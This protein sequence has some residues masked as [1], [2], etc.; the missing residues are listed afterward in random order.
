MSSRPSSSESLAF[1]PSSMGWAMRGALDPWDD[2]DVGLVS[3]SLFASR[4][5]VDAAIGR[6]S[7]GGGIGG[8][9]GSKG[10]DVC[11]GGGGGTGSR[12][13]NG[14]AAGGARAR[15]QSAR[16]AARPGL[17]TSRLSA[18][19][20]VVHG[21]VRG[22]TGEGADK[23]NALPP[24]STVPPPSLRPPPVPPALPPN[25]MSKDG[26]HR[27]SSGDHRHI[28]G[29][30]VLHHPAPPQDPAPRRQALSRMVGRVTMSKS[31]PGVPA[32]ERR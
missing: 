9:S 25:R 7:G 13:G 8:G 16:P 19:R 24:D 2:G 15:P 28:P 30:H 10:R 12:V 11:G 18:N 14:R 4:D 6:N 29:R 1:A 27:V 21:S 3:S 26:G 20:L 31:D 23:S 5:D 32:S 22:W 17:P